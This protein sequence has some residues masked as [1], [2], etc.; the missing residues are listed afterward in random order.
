MKICCRCGQCRADADFHKNA[1]RRDGLSQWCKICRKQYDGTHRAGYRKHQTSYR[2]RKRAIKLLGPIRSRARKQGIPYDL[3]KFVKQIQNRIDA[4]RCEMTGTPFDL[5][6]SRAFD[7]PSIDRI[8][9][10][11]GYL[12]RN[13]R[14][15]CL[16]MN[17]ALNDWGEEKLL[18][19]MRFWAKARGGTL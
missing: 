16:A 9:P 18:V 2:L 3:D 8:V 7:V 5:H 1:S 10:K 6:G 19:V 15:V 12:Y 4:G 11:R 17:C 13:I 14:V